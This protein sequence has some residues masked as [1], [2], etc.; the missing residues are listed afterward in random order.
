MSSV[1]CWVCAQFLASAGLLCG[2]GTLPAFPGWR[3][4]KIAEATA[5]SV[6]GEVVARRTTAEGWECPVEVRS[7]TREGDEVREEL[8]TFTWDEAHPPVRLG[9]R[10]GPPELESPLCLFDAEGRLLLVSYEQQASADALIGWARV[11]SRR[12]TMEELDWAWLAFRNGGLQL[13]A[14]AEPNFDPEWFAARPGHLELALRFGDAS[15]WLDA[16]LQATALSPEDVEFVRMAF[17][18]PGWQNKALHILLAHGLSVDPSEVRDPTARLCARLAR[19]EPGAQDELHELL[20]RCAEY[21][22]YDVQVRHEPGEYEAHSRLGED[23]G[24]R[25]PALLEAASHGSPEARSDLRP[26]VRTQV[27]NSVFAWLRLGGSAEELLALCGGKP[28]TSSAELS[29]VPSMEALRLALAGFARN[30]EPG[31]CDIYW[32]R[33][34]IEHLGL[35][36]GSVAREEVLTLVKPVLEEA[37]LPRPELTP[38]QTLATLVRLGDTDAIGMIERLDEDA[39]IR[40]PIDAL[41]LIPEQRGVQLLVRVFARALQGFPHDDT[42]YAEGLRLAVTLALQKRSAADRA[43]AL[44]LLDAHWDKLG[45]YRRDPAVRWALGE[46]PDP[47]LVP[48]RLG[49]RRVIEDC[50]L[51]LSSEAHLY[52]DVLEPMR[53]DPRQHSFAL[54]ILRDESSLAAMLDWLEEDCRKESMTGDPLLLIRRVGSRSAADRLFEL[55]RRSEF[56]ARRCLTALATFD[57]PANLP[58]LAALCAEHPGREGLFYWR[59]FL[60]LLGRR[61]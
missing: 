41:A 60:I 51:D 21:L 35:H 46:L 53:A 49:S 16:R 54:A 29:R 13:P 18:L 28:P 4:S 1:L 24:R 19:R 40:V 10:Y 50:G 39:L 26:F 38:E 9:Q 2:Q 36:L 5:G 27:E 12:F 61:D 11:P 57:S 3:L 37:L 7:V 8:H 59:A 17:A 52:A 23:V 33:W 47:A 45:P 22:A 32:W 58:R 56:G 15:A 14:R 6:R 30:T 55:G 44:E 43:L 48:R 20:E 25:I 31:K 34:S 42:G